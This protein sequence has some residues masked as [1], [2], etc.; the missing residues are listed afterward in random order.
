M[1]GD[2]IDPDRPIAWRAVP[3]DTPVRSSDGLAVG[4]LYDL[5][6]SE[7]E[8]IFHGIVLQLG[9]LG[10]RVFV[11]ADQ[12]PLMTTSHVDV[13]LTSEELHSLPEH[14]EDQSFRLGLTGL[15]SRRVGWVREKDR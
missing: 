10:R 2:V 15:I 12:V 6:G 3:Q 5:L 1:A 14:S 7:D 8:D 9:R 13:A 4:T 11:A